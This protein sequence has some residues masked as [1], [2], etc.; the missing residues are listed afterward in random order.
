MPVM[1]KI[2]TLISLAFLATA[3][4]DTA[5]AQTANLRYEA[6]WGGLHAADFALTFGVGEAD[7]DNWF[8]LRTKG[9]TDWIARLDIEARGQGK[10]AHGRPLEGVAYRVDYTNRWRSR[11][12][13]IRYDANGGPALTTLETHQENEP[14]E[15]NELP[16]EYR[17]GVL[18]PL[19]GLAEAIR[20]LKAHL[21]ADGPRQFRLSLFDGRR[22]FDLEG[23]FL[24]RKTRTIRDKTH[25]VYHLRLVT[26]AIA[27]FKERFKGVWDGSSFDVYLTRDGRY[28]PLQ[29]DS[30]GP[31]PLLNLVEECEKRCGV[32]GA[33]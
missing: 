15:D 26:R 2:T 24:G 7:Y 5:A 3:G 22:R 12:M 32:G 16:P 8:R 28:L 9:M 20:R 30:V 1:H 21:E 18:D 25:E 11:T 19:T 13:T 14:D 23:E 17:T 4:A 10:V 6:H 29:I 27:G 31:G 33:E